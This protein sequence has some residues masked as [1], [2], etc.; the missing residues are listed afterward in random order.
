METLPVTYTLGGWSFMDFF[1]RIFPGLP[2]WAVWLWKVLLYLG[3]VRSKRWFEWISVGTK[4]RG[5]HCRVYIVETK[6]YYKALL[7]MQY[8][9]SL[10]PRLNNPFH[11]VRLSYL[12]CI[13]HYKVFYVIDY[14]SSEKKTK[15]NSQPNTKRL[16]VSNHSQ[17]EDIRVQK[18][19]TLLKEGSSSLH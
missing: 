12:Y 3:C 10:W 9:L 1:D 16:T 5:Q 15:H 18:H 4:N 14:E 6:L 13:L 19:K 8:T 7:N 11:C 17:N 2:W